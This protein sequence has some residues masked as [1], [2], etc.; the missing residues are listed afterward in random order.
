MILSSGEE[1]SLYHLQ[2]NM[3]GKFL[4]A[5]FNYNS[6]FSHHMYHLCFLK[7]NSKITISFTFHLSV[8]NRNTHLISSLKTV[9]P[10]C[11]GHS[12]SASPRILLDHLSALR[13]CLFREFVLHFYNI[14]RKNNYANKS[15]VKV[16]ESSKSSHLAKKMHLHPVTYLFALLHFM[17]KHGTKNWRTSYKVK[18]KQRQ[19]WLSHYEEEIIFFSVP[20]VQK[21]LS[22]KLHHNYKILFFLYQ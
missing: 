5:L 20:L 22:L 21:N 8:F 15:P 7:Y 3:N 14:I 16:E 17:F 2:P 10:I 19:M 6:L 11:L 13:K 12:E 18:G 9:W 4:F 1:S